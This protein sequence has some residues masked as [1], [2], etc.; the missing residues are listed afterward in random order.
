MDFRIDPLLRLIKTAVFCMKNIDL[1]KESVKIIGIC[2]WYNKAIQNELNF[3]MS[4][5]R[6]MEDT[7]VFIWRKD[8]NILINS[9]IENCLSFSFDKC[10]K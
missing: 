10:P 9:F 8:Y 4:S 7:K 6:I 2:F 1:N 5:F 3:K